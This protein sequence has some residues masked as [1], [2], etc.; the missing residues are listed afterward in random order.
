MKSIK[1]W[2]NTP[3]KVVANGFLGW[4]C[5]LIIPISIY[6]LVSGENSSLI[7][8]KGIGFLLLA[9]TVFAIIAQIINVIN[10]YVLVG[11]CFPYIYFKMKGNANWMPVNDRRFQRFNG[12][13]LI[14]LS[15]I[16]F[17]LSYY[18][19]KV[20]YSQMYAQD[21]KSSNLSFK[22]S[23]EIPEFTLNKYSNPSEEEFH[24]L[25]ECVWNRFDEDQKEL[26]RKVSGAKANEVKQEQVQSYIIQFRNA[27]D[28]CGG[29]K[30]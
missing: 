19:P 24:L 14:L 5:L 28:A 18:V 27:L 23:Q 8:F 1:D 20:V 9:E 22:C 13:V 16:Y 11:V 12:L 26:S 4:G 21:K 6:F 30:F 3:F 10:S 29:N 17:P 25:C 2:G 7:S 15:L